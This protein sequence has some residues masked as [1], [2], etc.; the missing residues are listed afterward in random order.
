MTK[1]IDTIR[2]QVKRR[3]ITRLCHFTPSRNLAHI[4]TDSKGILAS[5]HLEWNEKAV[6]NPTD[7]ERLDGYPDHVCCSVQYPNAWYFKRARGQDSLFLDWVVLLINPRYLWR[8]GTKFCHRNAASEYGKLVKE[9][10]QGFT[11]LF[12]E[13]VQGSRIFRRGSRYPAFLSTDEQAEVLVPDLIQQEDVI[14]I[15]VQDD[16]QAKREELRLKLLGWDYPP[17][18]IVSEFFNPYELSQCLRNGKI[19]NERKHQHGDSND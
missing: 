8:T 15:A 2:A 12:A 4:A 3:G 6:F 19:P 11:A 9:G 18:V 17:I 1:T 7:I 14:G 16:D 13:T 10:T 5:I